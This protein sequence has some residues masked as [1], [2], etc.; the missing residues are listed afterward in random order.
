MSHDPNK[1]PKENIKED[2]K[3]IKDNVKE[4]AKE[5]K[6]KVKDNVND[7]KSNTSENLKKMK[8]SIKDGIKDG[9][10]AKKPKIQVPPIPPSR[11]SPGL[12][13]LAVL[14]VAGAYYYY[15]TMRK[16][17]VVVDVKNPPQPI[18]TTTLNPGVPVKVEVKK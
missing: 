11:I 13:G 18:Q 8:D 2:L 12:I 14:G 16:P 6:D 3:N 9:I 10:D 15:T 17:A 5:M 7:I 1:T 4:N